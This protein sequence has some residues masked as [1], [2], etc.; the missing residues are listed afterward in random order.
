MA[1]K[2]VSVNSCKNCPLHVYDDDGCNPTCSHPDMNHRKTPYEY[3][4]F[5]NKNAIN[6]VPNDCPLKISSLTISLK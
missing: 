1:T 3:D 5:N 4:C 6:T 2:E